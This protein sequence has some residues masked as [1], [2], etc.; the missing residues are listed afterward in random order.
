[1]SAFLAIGFLI[2]ITLLETIF[3]YLTFINLAITLIESSVSV[4]THKTVIIVAISAKL[5][6][7]TKKQ[8]YHKLFIP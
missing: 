1:M 8:Y 3:V 4:R 5:T 7:L 6:R 2:G